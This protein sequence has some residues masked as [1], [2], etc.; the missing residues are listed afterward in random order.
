MKNQNPNI[1]SASGSF[2]ELSNFQ[3]KNGIKLN[4]N[5][6][7]KKLKD[8]LLQ[9]GINSILDRLPFSI[10][11]F[12]GTD[13]LN[14]VVNKIAKDLENQEIYNT[15]KIYKTKTNVTENSTEEPN[16]PSTNTNPSKSR[17]PYAFQ[18]I[19]AKDKDNN[20]NE[21]NQGITF[22]SLKIYTKQNQ[23]EGLNTAIATALDTAFQKQIP[24]LVSQTGTP[25]EKNTFKR[26]IIAYYQ[27]LAS[28]LI[29]ERIDALDE[30]E[31]TVVSID[32]F[33]QHVILNQAIEDE[34]DELEGKEK[35]N[36]SKSDKKEDKKETKAPDNAKATTT[37]SAGDETYGFEIAVLISKY[38]A[39][40]TAELERNNAKTFSGEFLEPVSVE[41]VQAMGVGP[42]LKDELPSTEE[43]EDET[44]AKFS[45]KFEGKAIII[46]FELK[47]F[48]IGMSFREK[49]FFYM[50]FEL[51]KNEKGEIV[52]NN[53]I[54][55]GIKFLRIN[56]AS[57]LYKKDAATEADLDVLADDESNGKDHIFNKDFLNEYN[58]VVGAAI[59][60]NDVA[61]FK[62]V[63]SALNTNSVT[64]Y[65]AMRTG[66]NDKKLALVI[67][68]PKIGNPDFSITDLNIK[69]QIALGGN[70]AKDFGLAI[71]AKLNCTIDNQDAVFHILGKIY[72][73][74]FELSGSVSNNVNFKITDSLYLSELGILFGYDSITQFAIG[75]QG[76]IISQNGANSASLFAATHVNIIGKLIK[77]NM[78][79]IAI[80]PSSNK[81]VTIASLISNMFGVPE[82]LMPPY[83]HV[84]GV[85]DILI[86]KAKQSA[87]HSN[88]MAIDKR[89]SLVISHF[90]DHIVD[91]LKINE[92]QLDNIAIKELQS[93][94]SNYK[95][96]LITDHNRKL[97]YKIDYNGNVYLNSQFYCCIAET[98]IGAYKYEKGLFAAALISI[99]GQEFKILL[100]LDGNSL[101]AFA[102]MKPINLFGILK[103][104]ESA[105]NKAN[106]NNPNY[107]T[108]TNGLFKQVMKANSEEVG[109]PEVYL[110]IAKPNNGNFGLFEL[111][112]H[113]RV[114]LLNIFNVDA[115]IHIGDQVKLAFAIKLLN[116]NLNVIYEMENNEK[117]GQRKVHFSF[118]LD[119]GQFSD[120]INEV[121]DGVRR[122]VQNTQQA[123]NDALRS[124]EQQEAADRREMDRLR[125]REREEQARIDRMDCLE[126]AV[127]GVMNF[128]NSVKDA[129]V[130]LSRKVAKAAI[131]VAGKLV[132]AGGAIVNA[133]LS[134][135]D[136]FISLLGNVFSLNR[137]FMSSTAL[138]DTRNASLQFQLNSEISYSLFGFNKSHSYNYNFEFKPNANLI[139]SIKDNLKST[140]KSL[141]ID[142]KEYKNYENGKDENDPI[143]FNLPNNND[144]QQIMEET[145]HQIKKLAE[146]EEYK[147]YINDVFDNP[148][149]LDKIIKENNLKEEDVEKF[150]AFIAGNYDNPLAEMENLIST[151]KGEEFQKSFQTMKDTMKDNDQ[152]DDAIKDSL[153]NLDTMFNQL[154]KMV[155]NANV[156]RTDILLER[157]KNRNERK[158]HY[159]AI[160]AIIKKQEFDALRE[161]LRNGETPSFHTEEA[162]QQ[163]R[164]FALQL[165]NAEDIRLAIAALDKYYMSL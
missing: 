73:T 134:A 24:L 3:Q 116:F 140:V 1:I 58:L 126:K 96:Y 130:S 45:L 139:G 4:V 147:H 48:K 78:F 37:A 132:E 25:A 97:H 51:E 99:L 66:L 71:G 158:Q 155:E 127:H 106:K 103:I 23:F 68:V 162:K 152:I 89:N 129:I 17:T 59:N 69:G 133:A 102:A 47:R 32:K 5:K 62:T 61:L 39:V 105:V 108:K 163:F 150:K 43:D 146:I 113:G 55:E 84:I 54:E 8:T 95:N 12:W 110:K 119:V 124:I 123:L 57:L 82:A 98:Q 148:N 22:D 94:N 67:N 42:D 91:D 34:N 161:Q 118:A 29:D 117:S 63:G 70:P 154:N 15:Y 28:L 35:D 40:L 41:E 36:V 144:Y 149:N 65:L 145:N 83:F 153:H 104:E 160:E 143:V 157:S 49:Q 38:K 165:D 77:L 151:I 86:N 120:V 80:A 93:D 16:K 131:W 52:A 159:D 44:I 76:R 125:Q 13:T 138:I 109:G 135:V 111:K 121:K 46:W 85:G 92:K 10:K 74:G 60:L 137:L 19:I 79:S 75:L 128:L 136:A 2:G 107:I 56:K 141:I 30:E 6:I 100:K 101:E 27:A 88:N 122:V 53:V 18:L 31:P 115:Y 21:P 7:E 142:S 87:S 26:F 9:F 114:S 90:N 81:P 156:A 64:G 11:Y 50:G 14:E 33:N 72:T 20:A 112:A 164:D